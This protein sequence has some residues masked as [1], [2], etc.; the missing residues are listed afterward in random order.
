[1]RMSDIRVTTAQLLLQKNCP[2]F[3]DFSFPDT[4]NTRL[5]ITGFTLLW[6][7]S[8]R[9]YSGAILGLKPELN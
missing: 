2:L 3:V 6:R 4:V 5:A 9:R 1:M 7:A 8:S